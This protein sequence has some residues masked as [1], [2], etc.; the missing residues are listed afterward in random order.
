MTGG[1]SVGVAPEGWPIPD[2]YY[3]LRAATNTT[4]M[5]Q[6]ETFDPKMI[7]QEL[8]WLSRSE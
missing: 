2:G 7:D 3:P 4:E 5:W 1:E 8:A 6:E